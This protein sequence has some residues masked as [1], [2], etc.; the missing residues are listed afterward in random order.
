MLAFPA[1]TSTGTGPPFDVVPPASVFGVQFTGNS[2]A[3]NYLLQGSVNGTD[4]VNVA[5]ASTGRTG[6]PTV[7]SSTQGPFAKVRLQV[8]VNGSTSAVAG[9]VVA[10]GSAIVK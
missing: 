3:V 10:S 6:A 4:F 5:T 8:T 7:L 2:T 9:H 1:S